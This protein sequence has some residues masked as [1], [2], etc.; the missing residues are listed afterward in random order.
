MSHLTGT[1]FIVA[2]PIGNRA[3]ITTRALDT[4]RAVDLVAAEDTRNSGALLRHYGIDTP[5]TALHDHNERSATPALIQ[6]LQSGLSVALISD[7]GTPGISD[8]GALLVDAAL[9][10]GIT[11]TPIPG[12]SAV[13]T[14]MSACGFLQNSFLFYGFLPAKATARAHELQSLKTQPVTLVFYEAPHRIV[15]CLGA[16]E[17]AFG[18]ERRLAIG[19]E[20]TKVFETIHRCTLGEALLWIEADP[21]HQR[22]EFVLAVEGAPPQVNPDI[23]T[24]DVLLQALLEKCSVSDAVRIAVKVSGENRSKLYAR[25]LALAPDKSA[26]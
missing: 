17:K 9:N 19:R 15:E 23:S 14:L 13:T 8:P 3:D 4:L 25:A 12:P 22:G 16:L 24:H 20:L 18:P 10:A 2:T 26:D 6:K 7:A 5:L 11:V 21:N 1:L